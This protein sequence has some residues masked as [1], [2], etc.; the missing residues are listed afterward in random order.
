MLMK[1]GQKTDDEMLSNGKYFPN[2]ENIS[3]LYKKIVLNQQ[4]MVIYGNCTIAYSVLT[5]LFYIVAIIFY[6]Q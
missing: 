5:L 2:Y 4:S 1:P 6:V 3:Q